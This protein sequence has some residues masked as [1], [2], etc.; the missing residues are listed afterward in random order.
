M[1]AFPSCRIPDVVHPDTGEHVDIVYAPQRVLV[2]L[3]VEVGGRDQTTGLPR[4]GCD[5]AFDNAFMHGDPVK[6]VTYSAGHK[7]D[8]DGPAEVTRQSIQDAFEFTDQ[9]LQ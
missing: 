1:S 7:W 2:P 5:S 3:L 9:H 8:Q 4:N 6:V